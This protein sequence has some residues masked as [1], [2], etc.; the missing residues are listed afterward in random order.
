MLNPAHAPMVQAIGVPT[1]SATLAGSAGDGR[2]I[3]VRAADLERLRSSAES[4]F[5]A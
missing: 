3:S 1:I 4:A 5:P 2:Y